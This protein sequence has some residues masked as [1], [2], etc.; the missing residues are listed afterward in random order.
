VGVSVDRAGD[1]RVV[2]EEPDLGVRILASDVCD[3]SYDLY[4]TVLYE[5][6]AVPQGG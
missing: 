4:A 5:H 6:G 1:D 3:G 2:G